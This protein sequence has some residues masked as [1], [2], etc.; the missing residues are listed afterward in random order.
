MS[1]GVMEDYK[2]RDPFFSRVYYESILYV[3]FFFAFGENFRVFKSLF[4]QDQNKKARQDENG[5]FLFFWIFLTWAQSHGEMRRFG[6]VMTIGNA[7]FRSTSTHRP[8]RSASLSMH[9]TPFF[10]L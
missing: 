9:T 3:R 2:L 6:A 5:P 10:F 8:F 7:G 4:H 1:V